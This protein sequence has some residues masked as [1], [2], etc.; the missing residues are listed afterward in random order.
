MISTKVWTLYS[1]IRQMRIKISDKSLK[2]QINEVTLWR[3]QASMLIMQ[4][5]I[6][7]SLPES[8]P[9]KSLRAIT[10]IVGSAQQAW[11]FPQIIVACGEPRQRM[12]KVCAFLLVKRMTLPMLVWRYCNKIRLIQSKMKK[13]KYL[14]L[15]L[16]C[17]AMSLSF[18]SC[19]DDDDAESTYTFV[20]NTS[21]LWGE[22]SVI[23]FECDKNGVS[24]R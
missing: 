24:I 20:Y 23:L 14:S 6:A 9:R 15:M 17:A 19:S 3:I 18:T 5:Y 12:A 21:T 7:Q 2:L 1:D 10:I 13:L 4:T 11:T 16:L 8:P 22:T